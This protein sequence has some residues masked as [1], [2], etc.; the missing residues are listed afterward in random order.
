MSSEVRKHVRGRYKSL[1]DVLWRENERGS[2]THPG[3]YLDVCR[4][5]PMMRNQTSG[6]DGERD[7]LGPVMP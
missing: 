5:V 3:N 2:D 4:S 6:K 1:T 7:V